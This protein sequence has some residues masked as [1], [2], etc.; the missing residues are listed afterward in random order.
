MVRRS[1]W[2]VPQQPF[3]SLPSTVPPPSNI[4]VSLISFFG[5]SFLSPFFGGTHSKR[6]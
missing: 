1:T 5:S 3:R 4:M 6:K 2:Q